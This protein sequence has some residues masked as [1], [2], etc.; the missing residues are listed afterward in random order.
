MNTQQ[1]LD[2][3]RRCGAALVIVDGRL[4]ASPPDML[5]ADLKAA[6]R[7]RAAEIK[8]RLLADGG[9]GTT[10]PRV[11]QE[12]NR[13]SDG[14]RPPL[15]LHRCGALFCRTCHVLSPSAHRAGCD[16]KRFDPCGSRWFWLSAHGAIKCVGC[17]APSD[18]ALVEAWV[19]AHKTGEEG[20]GQ[21]I[22]AEVLSLLQISA[23]I[24]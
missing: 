16:F 11:W 22:P 23:P 21:E 4:K 13:W 17:S 9:M 15:P 1:I 2:E 3:V 20:N 8:E 24:Q 14:A 19:L 6:I 12:R 18:L 5:P 7:E 10:L